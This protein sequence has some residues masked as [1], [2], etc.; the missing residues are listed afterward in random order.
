MPLAAPAFEF[1]R[2]VRGDSPIT[3]ERFASFPSSPPSTYSSDHQ[4]DPDAVNVITSATK[5]SA[6]DTNLASLDLDFILGNDLAVFRALKRTA[7][8]QPPHGFTSLPSS[9]MVMAQR[10]RRTSGPA[11]VDAALAEF[12]F[13]PSARWNEL[14]LLGVAVGPS[15]VAHAAN[16]LG[17]AAPTSP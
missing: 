6:P 11:A 3:V 7:V 14:V 15:A 10:R 17:L 2:K 9:A 16:V 8:A 4:L 13:S 5:R 12:L 1:D